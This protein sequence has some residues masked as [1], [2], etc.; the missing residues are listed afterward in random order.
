MALGRE[1]ASLK[2]QGNGWK[3][4]LSMEDTSK[5]GFGLITARAI[6]F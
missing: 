3:R 4:L 6:A 5:K 2:F 1:G